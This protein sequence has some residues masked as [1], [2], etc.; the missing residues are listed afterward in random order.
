MSNPVPFTPDYLSHQVGPSQLRMWL[1]G[2]E[3]L[4][5]RNEVAWTLI[6]ICISFKLLFADPWI[7]ESDFEH[8]CLLIEKFFPELATG[9]DGDNFV[10]Y[11]YHF[12]VGHYGYCNESGTFTEQ[13]QSHLSAALAGD[14]SEVSLPR[15]SPGT[16]IP[17]PTVTTARNRRRNRTPPPSQPNGY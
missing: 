8:L 2:Y 9:L 15:V 17:F 4:Q 11:L 12:V 16:L 3:S 10:Y 13:I 14:M 7:S 6:H 1:M 5:H